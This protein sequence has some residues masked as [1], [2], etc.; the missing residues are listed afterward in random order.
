MGDV[1]SVCVTASYVRDRVVG[2]VLQLS[3]LDSIEKPLRYSPFGPS[4]PPSS[5]P[6][7]PVSPPPLYPTFRASRPMRSRRS[8]VA[9]SMW[10]A[11][12]AQ[13][14]AELQRGVARPRRLRVDNE[15]RKEERADSSVCVWRGKLAPFS[16]RFCSHP[17]LYFVEF[18]GTLLLADAKLSRHYYRREIETDSRCH[19]KVV[20]R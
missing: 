3:S 6:F 11:H 10:K 18:E 15:R 7:T 4:K 2:F 17:F 16:S 5:R 8:D 14:P 13:H 12:L 19:R 20:F 1:A 9:P